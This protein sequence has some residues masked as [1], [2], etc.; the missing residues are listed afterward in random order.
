[1]SHDVL[2]ISYIVLTLPWM[3]GCT[4]LATTRNQERVNSRKR[5]KYIG[6]AFF[7]TI[8]P[9]IYLYIQHKKHRIPGA[10]SRYAY[11]EWLLIAL[12]IA[13]DHQSATELGHLKFHLQDTSMYAYTKH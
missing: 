11:F 8:V 9:L 13:F 5:R 1:M 6:T 3:I 7:A 10:Y 2:M 4:Y 12:D